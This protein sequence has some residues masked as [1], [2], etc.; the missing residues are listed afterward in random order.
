MTEMGTHH[1]D[2]SPHSGRP[3]SRDS[4]QFSDLASQA[5]TFFPLPPW[6][7]HTAPVILPR[8]SA[9]PDSKPLLLLLHPT[10]NRLDSE[11]PETD[12][13]RFFHTGDLT[14]KRQATDRGQSIDK[15]IFV[16]FAVVSKPHHESRNIAGH[17][18]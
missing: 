11:V 3:R 5:S 16:Q 2:L 18:M 17:I 15:G 8:A 7:R 12:Q 14:L 10:G 1:R 13:N 9:S 6:T 4:G